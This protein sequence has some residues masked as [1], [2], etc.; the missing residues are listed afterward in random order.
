MA[1]HTDPS[2]LLLLLASNELLLQVLKVVAPWRRAGDSV[3]MRVAASI[4]KAVRSII[5]VSASP[6][7]KLGQAPK[8]ALLASV[9]PPLAG[10]VGES[11][12]ATVARTRLGPLFVLKLKPKR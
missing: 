2:S 5:Y 12:V 9:L 8:E 7:Y 1:C 6:S 11:A 3:S 10:F 4:N